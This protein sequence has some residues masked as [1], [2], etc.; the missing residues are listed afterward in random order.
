MGVSVESFPRALLNARI[1]RSPKATLPRV[2]DPRILQI[3][4]LSTLLCAGA[5]WRAFD[6]H[7]SH[8]A[9]TFA[10]A[11]TTQGICGRVFGQ[12]PTSWRSAIITSIGLSLLLRADNLW[13]H[14]IATA[15]AIGAKFIIRVNGKHVF[16]P[17]NLGVIFALLVLPGTWISAG[18][19]GQELIGAGWIVLLGFTVASRAKSAD[20]S[21]SFLLAYSFLLAMRTMRLEQSWSIP[22]HQL[23]NG[24]LVLFAFFMISDPMTIPDRRSSRIIHAVSV[25]I[26][27]YGWQ[28]DLYRTNGFIWA[29]FS[30]SPLVPLWDW[31]MPGE[32]Y[33]WINQ[34]VGS[35]KTG[36]KQMAIGLTAVLLLFLI[37]PLQTAHAFCGFYV[38]KADTGL[39]NHASQVV[40]VRKEN[41]NVISIMNDYAGEPA[42]F[43]LVVPVP[44]VLQKSQIHIGDRELF[45]RLDAYSAPRLVEY[46]DP[47]PCALRY[48]RMMS[49]PAAAGMAED[50][51][52]KRDEA[53]AKALGVTIAARYTVGE[54]DIVILSATQSD[55]LETWLQQSGYKLPVGVSRALAPYIHQKMK[56]FVA[57]VNLKEHQKSGL[58][59]L[60]PIQFAFDSPKFMLPIR[61]GMINAQGPQDLVIYMLTQDGRVEPTNYRTNKMPA[62]MDLPE[63]IQKDF[64][65]FYIAMFDHQVDETEMHAVFTEYVWNMGWCDPCAAPPLSQ[66]ELRQLGVFWLDNAGDSNGGAAA[67]RPNYFEQVPVVLTRLHVRYSAATFPE[68]LSFQETDDRQNFQA[69]YVLRHAWNGSES[70]CPAAKNYFEELQRRRETEA[71]ALADLTGWK[72]E[73]IYR[74]A[75][76]E[77]HGSKKPS[78]WWDKLWQ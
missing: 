75:G 35:M 37:V 13:A 15:V 23:S 24:A 43:A 64:G 55:G 48:E 16:N 29:L 27:A 4:F 65:K 58:S 69:S 11:L 38:G 73:E 12:N 5:A 51:V 52:A 63:Y 67:M 61:L 22:A 56:F 32:R 30:A 9:L 14:P 78:M 21:L 31:V 41:R 70:V 60:R 77:P 2:R 42:D 47:D 10:S 34:G 44:V 39:Y 49:A 74:K 25:A 71:S 8:I 62:G 68:D 33:Q 54:Y 26:L 36:T 7:L 1:A 19:W 20:I 6:L 72:L 45:Q 57:R 76:L 66:N 46:Y 28:F 18:Q 3:L 17:A 40:Y 53:K 50:M 59:Y